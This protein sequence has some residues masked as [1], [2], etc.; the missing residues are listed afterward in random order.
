MDWYDE[1]TEQKSSTHDMICLN[2]GKHYVGR[3]ITVQ[4]NLNWFIT[5]EYKEPKIGNVHLSDQPL[6]YWQ[7][8]NFEKYKDTAQDGVWCNF[9]VGNLSELL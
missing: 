6:I 9:S 7:D 1:G 3:G 2:F 8:V 4:W 5:D